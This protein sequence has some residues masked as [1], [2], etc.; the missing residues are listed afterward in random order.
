MKA[1]TTLD[2]NTVVSLLIDNLEQGTKDAV[3]MI[4]SGL[5]AYLSDH[6][7]V[8]GLIVFLIFIVVTIKA[9]LGRWGALGSFLYN[10]IYFGTLFLV[11]LI[12]GPEVFLN[13]WFGFFT[14]LV[15]YPA[16]YLLVGW[17]LNKTHLR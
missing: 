9:M 1:T 7:I 17:I 15:L 3:N 12:W 8:F 14:A 13:D 11:G 5:I 2:A 16:T 10:L 6:W 4:W